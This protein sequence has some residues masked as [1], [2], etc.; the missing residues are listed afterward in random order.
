ML[1]RSWQTTSSDVHNFKA[2]YLF[3][4]SLARKGRLTICNNANSAQC[5]LNDENLDA[6]EAAEEDARKSVQNRLSQQL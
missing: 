2:E 5:G 1:S 3:I 6:A 4:K